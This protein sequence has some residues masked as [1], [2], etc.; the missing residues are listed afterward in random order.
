MQGCWSHEFG[1]MSFSWPRKT[2]Q[3]AMWYRNRQLQT[4]T[5]HLLTQSPQSQH[6]FAAAVTGNVLPTTRN[7]VRHLGK[8]KPSSSYSHVWEIPLQKRAEACC[9][10]RT[11]DAVSKDQTEVG[12]TKDV[13][14]LR[15]GPCAYMLLVR[16][17]VALFL[18]ECALRPAQCNTS[19]VSL[20]STRNK[21]RLSADRGLWGVP[22]ALGCLAV[23]LM[24]N[25]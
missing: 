12:G 10:K 4:A 7:D 21:F 25:V 15:V 8:Q 13:L 18:A 22:K 23:M 17:P 20:E 3:Q 9:A 1:A 6:G 14:R 19:Q 24:R 2:Y 5:L 16:F 11:R